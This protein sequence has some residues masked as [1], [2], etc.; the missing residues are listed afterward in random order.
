MF[1]SERKPRIFEGFSTGLSSKKPPSA[2]AKIPAPKISV[3]K[4]APVLGI[5]T[6][7]KSGNGQAIVVLQSLEHA[8]KSER[9]YWRTAAWQATNSTWIEQHNVCGAHLPSYVSFTDR[10]NHRPSQGNDSLGKD[11]ASTISEITKAGD[12]EDGEEFLFY[13]NAL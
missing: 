2:A 10:P 6:I 8:P 9:S 11:A 7:F 5:Q 12:L 1:D 13:L 3:A 4:F